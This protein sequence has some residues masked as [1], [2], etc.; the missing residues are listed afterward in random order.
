MENKEKLL[1]GERLRN[2]RLR[3]G[4]T[5]EETADRLNISLRYYQML[6]RGEKLGSVDILLAT[7]EI[8]DCSLDYL[9]R[10]KLPERP[11]DPL[12]ARLN[13]LSSRQR[14]YAEKLLELWMESLEA[15]DLP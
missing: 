15:G 7:S 14:G 1:C 13:Q 2:L 3:R 9:L 6:E 5:Q 10:G 11:A 4:L 12:T 8:M